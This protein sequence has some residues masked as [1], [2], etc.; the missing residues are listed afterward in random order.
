LELRLGEAEHLNIKAP[1][2]GVVT[3]WQ[4]R[5][6]LIRRPVERGQNLMTIVEKDSTWL[7]EL[8]L[9][10]RRVGHMID[11]ASQA[12]Q[13]EQSPRVTF[14]LVSHPGVEFEGRMMLV[15]HQIDVHSDE[16]NTCL[17]RVAFA[18]DEVDRE[19]LRTGTRVNAK[20][21]CG[22]RSV[23]YVMF[24]EA[25]EAIHSSYLLWF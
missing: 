25:I 8:E 15:D 23:G 24:H 7:L 3:N 9:P 20:I 21:H 19:L 18:N 2:D 1:I 22:Q 11:A 5:Q 10:E 17:V 4:A 12:A 14:S 16:G 13:D 6:N